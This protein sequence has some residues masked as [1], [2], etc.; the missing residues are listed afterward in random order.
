[1]A[2]DLEVLV[3]NK[4]SAASGA[5]IVRCLA[6]KGTSSTGARWIAVT[7]GGRITEGGRDRGVPTLL[8]LAAS[9]HADVG[10]LQSRALC[11]EVGEVGEVGTA[12]GAHSRLVPSTI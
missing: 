12:N 9:C 8:V 2:A 4:S 10:S 7:D 11:G 5:G 3:T 6:Q 1:M